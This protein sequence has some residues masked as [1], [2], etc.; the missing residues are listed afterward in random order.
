MPLPFVPVQCSPYN[1]AR[2]AEGIPGRH[3]ESGVTGVGCGQEGNRVM[4]SVRVKPQERMQ[5]PARRDAS[6][7]VDFFCRSCKG[8]YTVEYLPALG[9]PL[10]CRCGATEV[11]IYSAVKT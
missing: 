1:N 4:V 8:H 3:P 7:D 10:R 5:I 9:E 11:M 6:F 2:T